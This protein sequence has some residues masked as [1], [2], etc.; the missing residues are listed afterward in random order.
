LLNKFDEYSISSV[1]T[2]L[3]E[4]YQLVGLTLILVPIN[5]LFEVLKWKLLI[6]KIQNMP[7]VK[8]IKSINFG[9]SLAL[10]TPNNIGDFGGRLLYIEKEK[11]WQAIFLDSFLSLTQLFVTIS[12]GLYAFPYYEDKVGLEVLL[13]NQV[14]KYLSIGIILL[15][16]IGFLFYKTNGRLMYLF[17]RKHY[18]FIGISILYLV[19]AVIP[20]G[21]ISALAVRASVA[22]YI[23]DQLIS[24]GEAAL[25]A[26][27]VLWV[28]NLLLP[29]LIGLLNLSQIDWMS[30]KS[31]LQE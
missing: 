12:V 18:A 3:K 14:L 30:L 15:L 13:S 22:F 29:A 11:R 23:F 8:A 4:N 1:W 21:W 10:I 28:F 31:E 6:D 19:T 2:S 26:S 16:L 27:S 7:L 24:S 17:L 5:W 25:L 9:I 20:T